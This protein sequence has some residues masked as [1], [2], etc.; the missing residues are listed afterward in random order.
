MKI[1]FAKLLTDYNQSHPLDK[2]SKV[3]LAREMVAAGIMLSEISAL[4]MMRYN[5][6]GKAKSIDFLMLEFLCTKFNVK[7]NEIIQ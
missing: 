5:S 1:D 7:P 2:L 4:N 6:A 3:K